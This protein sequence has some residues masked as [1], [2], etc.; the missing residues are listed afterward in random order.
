MARLPRLVLP[1]HAHYVIQ[2]ALAGAT[3]FADAHDRQAFLGH[4]HDAAAQHGVQVHAWAL[5]PH[6]VQL[7]VTPSAAPA[8]GLCVQAVG[9]R[10]VSAY[11][12]RHG[13]R[14]TLWDGR[15]RAG[16]V[17]PGALR[18]DVLAL[19]DG[20]STEP[21]VTS[22]FTR[23]GGGRHGWLVDPPEFWQLGN[24]PFDREDAYRRLLDGTPPDDGKAAA[25]RRCAL[26]GWPLAS[27][28]FARELGEHF[29]RPSRPRR[30]GRPPRKAATR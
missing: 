7:L 17:E 29:G 12:R 4:L 1:G 19:V 2:R 11:N 30:A 10:Y 13:R 6:E 16:V 9:R 14:G 25:L 27:A 28:D 18:L 5:L 26:G 15:Y 3:A 20:Q 24:T 8:L 21:G 22:A 23:L